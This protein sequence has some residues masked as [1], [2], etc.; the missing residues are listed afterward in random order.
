[1]SLEERLLEQARQLGFDLAGIAAAQPSD[2]YALYRA[3]LEAGYAG[4]MGYLYEHAEARQD[5][6]RVYPEAQAVVMVALN[7]NPGPNAPSGGIA[8]Y[9]RTTDYHAVLRERLKSL[10][11]WLK[12]QVP[13]A[14]GRVCVDTAP[15]LERDFA[16]RAG[17]GWQAK[18][19]MLIHPR[20]GSW[21][22]LGALLVNVP[23]KPSEPFTARH[24]GTCTRCLEACPTGA[25]VA[26]YVLDARRCISTWTIELKRPLHEHEA[27]NLHGWLFGCDICQEV[28]PWNRKAPLA[29][30]LLPR[31]DLVGLDPAELLR[32]DNNAFRTRFQGTALFPRPGRPVV[33]R[34]AALL[35][36]H[37]GD[38]STLDVLRRAAQDAEPLIAEAARWAIERIE[39]RDGPAD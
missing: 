5:L 7:Y 24:C 26:P 9:A 31:D 27:T 3:W 35:L 22:V 18:N 23:L 4:E 32:L 37:S 8:R 29:Q 15:L 13:G 21:L 6:S 10:G 17:L 11:G 25:F 1:M 28:C 19:T 20:L 2:Q 34:N 12:A 30:M 16:R 14:W 33:L 38:R 39:A 36:G